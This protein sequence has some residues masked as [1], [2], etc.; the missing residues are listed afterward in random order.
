MSA[1]AMMKVR[2][3]V[4]EVVAHLQADGALAAPAEARALRDLH[5]PTLRRFAAGD[6]MPTDDLHRAAWGIETAAVAA[7]DRELAKK[8]GWAA[9]YAL[10]LCSEGHREAILRAVTDAV[11]SI[12]V[13]TGCPARISTGGR[14]P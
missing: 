10:V 3:R 4:L 1:E 7:S 9:D 8:A 11:Q 14:S 2:E 6:A 5:L 12:G 13:R